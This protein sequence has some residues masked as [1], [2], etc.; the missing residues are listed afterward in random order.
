MLKKRDLPDRTIKHEKALELLASQL[1]TYESLFASKGI[2]KMVTKAVEMTGIDLKWIF[3]HI[4]MNNCKEISWEDLYS[5]LF[6]ENKDAKEKK[7]YYR[8]A[9][10]LRIPLDESTKISQQILKGFW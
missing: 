2:S 6:L 1:S 8:K 5:K 3:D 10:N 7:E 9:I 4:F